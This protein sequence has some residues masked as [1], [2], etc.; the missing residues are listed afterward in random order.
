LAR[1][2]QERF[3]ESVSSA[4]GTSVEE[5]QERTAEAGGFADIILAAASRVG[6]RGDSEYV[7]ILAQ[8]VA[9]TLVDSAKIHAHSIPS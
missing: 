2:S 8:L 1:H 3:V 6:E 5:L 4:A 9:A 7:D